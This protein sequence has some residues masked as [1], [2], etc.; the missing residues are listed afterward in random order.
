MRQAQELR[1]QILSL[2]QARHVQ[3]N[4]PVSALL[5]TW[6]NSLEEADL[7]GIMPASM[8]SVLWEAFSHAARWAPEQGCQIN[9]LSCQDG[10]GGVAT[11]LLILNP[12]MPYL[13]DAIVM[14]LRNQRIV[15]RAILNSVLAVQRDAAG[16]VLRV[17]T[18]RPQSPAAG[19]LESIV[20]C[21]RYGSG[22]FLN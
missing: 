16:T 4:P 11:A 18:A 14:S 9:T 8:A 7:A 21:L 3:D 10:R 2:V 22:E 5:E 19:G 15:S 17:E 6:L 1:K 12:D 20:I 13:V